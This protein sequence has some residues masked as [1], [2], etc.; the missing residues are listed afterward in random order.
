M[1]S[2]LVDEVRN[3][4][5]DD[6]I[7]ELLD[8]IEL[9]SQS[10]KGKTVDEWLDAVDYTGNDDYQPTKF[11]LKFVN[12]MKL[13]DGNETERLAEVQHAAI[14]K[15]IASPKDIARSKVVGEAEYVELN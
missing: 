9:L 1:S 4:F 6:N 5:P 15:G 12:F 2:K 7:D 13:V 3:L 14:K 10:F 11:A 8:E